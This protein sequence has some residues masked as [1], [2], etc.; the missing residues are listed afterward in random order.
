M[1]TQPRGHNTL[2]DCRP[3]HLDFLGAQRGCGRNDD[4]PG[5]EQN[6]RNLPQ[7]AQ[8]LAT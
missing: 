4:E 1:V 2:S 7:P 6:V 8:M 3:D 5:I